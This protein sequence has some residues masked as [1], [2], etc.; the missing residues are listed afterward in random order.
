MSVSK[1]QRLKKIDAVREEGIDYT[2][3][4]ELSKAFWER[5]VVEYPE[6]KKSVTLRVDADIIKWFKSKGKGYQTK[7]NAILRSY[8]EAHK[9]KVS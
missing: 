9:R 6:K 2:D 1:K 5:A 7:I 3:I 4:P 8:Y